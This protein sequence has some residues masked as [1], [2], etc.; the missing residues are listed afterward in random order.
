MSADTGVLPVDMSLWEDPCQAVEG[1]VDF[2]WSVLLL[3]A[4]TSLLG[5]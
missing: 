5:L 1:E 3:I 4:L 2:L